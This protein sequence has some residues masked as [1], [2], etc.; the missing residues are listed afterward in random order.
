[1]KALE[2]RTARLYE[3]LSYPQKAALALHFA[4]APGGAVEL[5]RIHATVPRHEYRA[6]DAQYLAWERALLSV[7][8]L[9]GSEW[10]RAKAELAAAAGYLLGLHDAGA[11]TGE[12]QERVHAAKVRLG[13]LRAALQEVCDGCGVDLQT[14]MTLAAAGDDAPMAA[15]DAAQQRQIAD[16]LRARLPG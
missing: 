8:A 14:A 11:D 15:P 13:S 5:A 12:A 4:C 7:A 16:E 10:W 2:K 1:M 3:G 6:M 9:W